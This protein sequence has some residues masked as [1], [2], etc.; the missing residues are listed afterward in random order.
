MVPEFGDN[1]M[2]RLRK[3]VWDGMKNKGVSFRQAADAIGQPH[4]MITRFIKGE[5]GIQLENF[6]KLLEYLELELKLRQR[7]FKWDL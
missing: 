1:A 7:E 5:R 4:Q 3:A 6:A 2:D